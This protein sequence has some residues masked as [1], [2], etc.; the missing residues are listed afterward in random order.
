MYNYFQK[1]NPHFEYN[2]ILNTIQDQN[3]PN[4][5]QAAAAN[6]QNLKVRSVIDSGKIS[7]IM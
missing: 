1:F 4:S 6:Y 7:N 3:F 5:A 2:A